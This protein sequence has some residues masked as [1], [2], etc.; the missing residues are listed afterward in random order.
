MTDLDF[1]RFLKVLKDLFPRVS[2]EIN[3]EV[4]NVWRMAMGSFAIDRCVAALRD[5][6]AFR[7]KWP[8]PSSIR[9]FLSA[10]TT[11][12]SCSPASYGDYSHEQAEQDMRERDAT[13]AA[14][15]DEDLNRHKASLLAYDWRV[16]WMAKREPRTL[17]WKAMIC[18]RVWNGLAPDEHWPEDV[19]D[20]PVFPAKGNIGKAVASAA[21]L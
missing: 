17:G 18:R 6:A 7:D 20:K 11:K 1:E 15:T 5:W 16:Q 2:A 8:H 10:N 3:P 19:P 21:K 12:K 9:A 14:M 4:S 13:I